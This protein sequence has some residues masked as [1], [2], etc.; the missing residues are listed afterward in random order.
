MKH[1]LDNLAGH[2]VVIYGAGEHTRQL[3]HIIEASPINLVAIADDDPGKHGT[4]LLGVP[5]SSL[6]DI[7]GTGANDI[8]ISSWMNEGPMYDSA[9]SHNR[10]DATLHRLYK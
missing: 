4:Q 7:A 10:K 6:R 2:S 3:A 1:T 9:E 5:I 8:V